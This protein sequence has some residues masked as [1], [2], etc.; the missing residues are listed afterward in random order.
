ME[1]INNV[2]VPLKYFTNSKYSEVLYTLQQKS[3]IYIYMPTI[4]KANYINLFYNNIERT[5]EKY[6]IKGFVI[7]NIS[8]IKLLE[9][10]LKD[11]KY[12]FELIANYTFNVFNNYTVNELKNLNF[13]RFTISPESDKEI[14]KNLSRSKY[15]FV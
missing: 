12:N 3:N 6:N 10:V 8:N 14:I 1:N 2:Y 5:V 7:S 15:E 13:S 4:I 9:D 11:K